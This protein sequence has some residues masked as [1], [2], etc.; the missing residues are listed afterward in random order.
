MKHLFNF[1]V[2]VNLRWKAFH[3]KATLSKHSFI[4][5]FATAVCSKMETKADLIKHT[6]LSKIHTQKKPHK[7]KHNDKQAFY[8]KTRWKHEKTFNS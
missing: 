8:S 2:V 7:Q 5:C 4:N 1:V 3:K 6:E